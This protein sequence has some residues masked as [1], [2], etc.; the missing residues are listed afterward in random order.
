MITA[1]HIIKFI[2]KLL[3]L[4]IFFPFFLVWAGSRY[5]TFKYVLVSNMIKSGMQ[6]EYAKKLARTVSISSIFSMFSKNG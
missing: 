5:L 1:I 6:K 3:L 2:I 4:I